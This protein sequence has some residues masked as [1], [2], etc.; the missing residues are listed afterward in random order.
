MVKKGK[1]AVAGTAM[2]FASMALVAVLLSYGSLSLCASVLLGES[3]KAGISEESSGDSMPD[4]DDAMNGDAVS[5]MGTIGGEENISSDEAISDEAVSSD[6]VDLSVSAECAILYCRNTGEIVFEKNA[7]MCHP[8]ASTT[9]IMTAIVAIERV[10]L[11]KPVL[12]SSDAVGI[13]GSSIYLY[14]GEELTMEALLY[15]LMLE[16]ANDAAAAIAISVAGSVEEFAVLMNEKAEELGLTGTHFTNPHGLDDEGHYTTAKDLAILTDY[17]LDNPTFRKIVST[18]KQTIPMRNGEGTRLLV[19]HNKLLKNYD[20][21]IGVKT[22]YTSASGRCLVSAAERDGLSFIS[23]TLNAPDDWRDHGAM[24][25]SGF[26]VYKTV[27]VADPGSESYTVDV[28][29]GTSSSVT[30]SNKEGLN[31]VLRAD[32]KEIQ[33]V[34]CLDQF[35]YAPIDCDSCLGR[36][37]FYSGEKYLGEL[38]LYPEESVGAEEYKKSFFEKIADFFSGLFSE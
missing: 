24:L 14:A 26:S 30:V 20:G 2:G 6:G 13:I 3:E 16:S 22:G 33:K 17:A 28:V 34:V 19:N 8:M 25:D 32:S 11:G 36:V 7:E 37:I 18:Y 9:K 23:V 31:A 15:A 10:S 35:Y 5:V 12:V 4:A 1:K 38:P 27:S 29:G 21:A